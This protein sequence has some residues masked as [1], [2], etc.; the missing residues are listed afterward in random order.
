MYRY[1]LAVLLATLSLP[2]HAQEWPTKPIRIVVPF[3]PGGAADVWA[4]V[5]ADPLSTAPKQPIVIENRAGASGNIG[6]EA[7]ARAAPDGYT[8]LQV[9][10]PHAINAA[11]GLG[12]EHVSDFQQHGVQLTGLFTDFDHLQRQTRQQWVSTKCAS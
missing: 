9:A 2:S 12:V 8:L 11:L 3:A 7:V 4:R 6:T 10:T 5:I 1:F